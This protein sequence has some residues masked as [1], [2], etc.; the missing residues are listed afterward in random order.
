MPLRRNPRLLSL[1]ILLV[2]GV[3]LFLQWVW[4]ATPGGPVTYVISVLGIVVVFLIGL[5]FRSDTYHLKRPWK[6]SAERS[7]RSLWDI[8]KG[9]L[10][11]GGAILVAVGGALAARFQII[12]DS[13]M[14]GVLI[15]IPAALLLVGGTYLVGRGIFKW[16]FGTES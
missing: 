1:L 3:A 14:P 13:A 11:W 12:P 16:L 6:L 4:P 2:A 15:L 10:C 7:R 5:G 8:V 9:L